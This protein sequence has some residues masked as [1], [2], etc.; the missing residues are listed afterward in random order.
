MKPLK[1]TM[2]AFGSYAGVAEVD[3]EAAGVEHGIFLLTGDTGAGKTT[4]FDAISYAL[5][6]ETSGDQR[7]G[8][9]M[10]SQYA[11]EETETYVELTF[12]YK[13]ERYVVRRSPAYQRFSKRRNK[14]GERTVTTT[15][16]KLSL[17]LPDG[18]EAPGRIGELNDRIRDIMGVDK[19]QFSQIAMIAQGEYLKLLHAS[20]KERKEIFSQIFNTGIY[21]RI[22][23]KLKNKNNELYGK[24]KE[25]ENLYFHEAGQIKYPFDSGCEQEREF[26]ELLSMPETRPDEI[27]ERIEEIVRESREVDE[28][29]KAAL[30]AVITSLSDKKNALEHAREKNRRLDECDAALQAFLK[31]KGQAGYWDEQNERL[32]RAEL[33]EPIY[34]AE[35]S[36]RETVKELDEIIRQKKT[37]EVE[38][39]QLNEQAE[40]A[41]AVLEQQREQLEKERPLLLTEITKLGEMMPSYRK[42]EEQK[43]EVKSAEQRLADCQEAEHSLQ[44]ASLGA[45]KKRKHLE[46]EQETLSETSR[47]LAE[48]AAEVERLRERKKEFSELLFHLDALGKLADEQKDKEKALCERQNSYERASREYDRRYRL[49]ISVQA[50][51]MAAELQEDEPCPVCGALEHPHKAELKA[52]DV[53]EEQVDAA[54]KARENAD[55]QVK[56]AAKQYQELA[57]RYGELQKRVVER[58]E[59]LLGEKLLG[60][61]FLGEK[62]FGEKLHEEKLQG[63]MLPKMGTEF[64]QWRTT[65]ERAHD[66]C[67]AA[68]E[69]ACLIQKDL[70]KKRERWLRNKDAIQKI[71][72]EL[73]RISPLLEQSRLKKNEAEL[74]RQRATMSLEQLQGALIW[75]TEEEASERLHTLER[76]KMAIE[77]GAKQAGEKAEQLKNSVTEKN[78]FLLSAQEK[79]LLHETKALNLRNRWMAMM[80]QQEFSEEVYRAAILT[81]E[82]KDELKKK[83]GA[84]DREFLEKKTIFEQCRKQTKG[85]ERAN[86]AGIQGEIDTLSNERLRLMKESE[87]FASLRSG[88]EAAY[89]NIKK[90]LKEREGLKEQR[91]MVET[92]YATADGKVSKSARIDFQTYVQRQYFKQMVNAANKRLLFMTDGKFMLQCRDIETLGK[93][94]EVGLDLDVYSMVSDRTRDVKT[95]SGGESFMAALSMA[96]GMADVI[97]NTAGSVSIDAMF[98]DE[99]FGSLDEDSRMKAIRILKDLAGSRRLVGIISHVTELK[100]Q[101]E[102]KLIVKKD[103]KGSSVHWEIEA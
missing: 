101:M 55:G 10:R 2:S 22:Q 46:Q 69:T 84:F 47:L 91:Q 29:K 7:D 11:K 27:I 100:E 39:A 87:E 14:N 74:L 81:R 94:G 4:I 37:L 19:R 98:I 43:K 48:N 86:E 8:T 61:K 62:L 32:R 40:A 58:T 54:G 52:E 5:Y 77:T 42:L 75:K 16:A 53:T 50:G 70:E 51:I 41:Q 38:L 88:N 35:Q 24:L 72:E 59:K 85:E 103:E 89:K 60:E 93:Q 95:L 56:A 71:L 99:G 96:L 6:G 1:I 76:K 44:A 12:L 26:S 23:Q 34:L 83:A 13:G 25:N 49:F 31:M 80:E 65:I 82:E 3:F 63:E 102:R 30:E 33:V 18:R 90:I 20:S 9:M 15:A 97:Q 67:G 79:M 78:A 57:G 68:Y 17:I 21:G 92:L 45:E 28:K 64:K 66:E 36:Y 73:E